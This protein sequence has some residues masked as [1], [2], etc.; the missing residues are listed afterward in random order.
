M[1]VSRNE[2]SIDYSDVEDADMTMLDFQNRARMSESDMNL[3]M[4]LALARRNSRNQHDQVSAQPVD[5]P[6]EETIYEGERKPN[7]FPAYA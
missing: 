5:M 1:S 4:Q 3:S 7:L 2:E 6:I